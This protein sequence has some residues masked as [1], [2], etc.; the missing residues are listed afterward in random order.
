LWGRLQASEKV[1]LTAKIQL[2]RPLSILPRCLETPAVIGAD[3]HPAIAFPLP[4]TIAGSFLES[5]AITFDKPASGKNKEIP[6]L[7]LF[8]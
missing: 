3:N 5:Q 4:V 8:V 7:Y 2:Q 6:Y 1:L